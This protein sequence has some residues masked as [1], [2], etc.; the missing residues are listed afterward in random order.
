MLTENAVVIEARD[1]TAL[2]KT[3][4]GEACSSC[5]AAGACKAMGGGKEMEVEVTNHLRARAGD[6]VELALPESSFLKAS[7]ATYAI[8]L[9]ALVGGASLGQ[10]LAAG[11]G[12]SPDMASIIL[13]GVGLGLAMPI[14]VLL[15]RWLGV[16]DE[17]IP[18]I[19]KVLPP[20]PDGESDPDECQ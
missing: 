4:R 5:S 2:V 9:V 7:L 8:P 6:R 3:Y 13:A 12:L 15:N 17:Y 18:R 19:V 14:V 11:M 16:K 1:L 10:I 20:L